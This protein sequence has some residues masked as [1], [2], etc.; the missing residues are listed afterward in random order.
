M[1][2]GAGIAVFIEMV[3]F[4]FTLDIMSRF[5]SLQL[6]GCEVLLAL[7]LLLAFQW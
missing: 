4:C 7:F 1:T 6:P 5:K 2:E 3:D